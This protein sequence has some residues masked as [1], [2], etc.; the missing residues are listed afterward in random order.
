MS[1]SSGPIGT[2]VTI[3]GT[4]FA[5][6][7]NTVT[8]TGGVSGT[9]TNSSATAITV[10]VP[11]GAQTGNVLLVTSG[12]PLNAGTFTVTTA[13]APTITNMS[14][15][16]GP[17]GTSVTITG[18]NFS[19]TGNIVTFIPGVQ[20]TI[21]NSTT[22]SIT[23]TVPSG[24]SSGPVIVNTA[25]TQLNAGI[26]TIS[27]G[28]TPI[29]TNMSPTSGPT[30]TTV[31][32][33]G[34][35]FGTTNTNV[36]F[37]P[38]VNGI[39]TTNTSTSITVMVPTGAQTGSVTVNTAGANLSAGTFTV[40]TG[41]GGT[42]PTITSIAPNSGII[43]DEVTI[44]GINFNT[45][46]INNTVTFTGGANATVKSATSTE[47]KVDVPTGAL[48]GQVTVSNAGGTANS[49]QTFTVLT[50]PQ[51]VITDFNPKRGAIGQEITIDGN[52]FNDTASN[53]TVTFTGGA[54]GNIV[55]ATTQKIVVEVPAGASDGIITVNNGV[56]FATTPSAFTIEN[57]PVI[58]KLNPASGKAGSAVT[59]E[60]FNFSTI[61]NENK[62]LF[63][64]ID[65]GLPIVNAAATE[66]E[67]TV[68]P[69]LSTGEHTVRLTV[70]GFNTVTS[71]KKY[72]VLALNSSI[73]ESSADNGLTVFSNNEGLN[74]SI[75]TLV[76]MKNPKITIYNVQ[77][78]KIFE[79][80]F[81]AEGKTEHNHVA[82]VD[83]TS[84]VYILNYEDENNSMM[85]ERFVVA[86]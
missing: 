43:G 75:K 17:I 31:T 54:V 32:I 29:V 24:A 61:D 41:G 20:G 49:P 85:S 67:V 23:V 22:S 44:T 56:N 52:L 18:T 86:Q 59:V 72:R 78:A 16:S 12:T 76:G 7:G 15:T 10:T 53:N 50:A 37:T 73:L 45:T 68:P 40:T 57:G 55:S 4:N 80:G 21:T 42:A 30:G 25:S 66:L 27:T 81:Y 70:T 82:E 62:V 36:V 48:T 6:S 64:S 11:N 38:S 35:N 33:S 83:L 65:A 19:T 74:V 14:P 69:G 9:I 1:P 3:S 58:V 63:G 26:F 79:Q 71:P 34:N 13:S 51:I 46:A 47:I 8:F 77:G 60:G 84:G 2:S 5:T 28:S 39:I